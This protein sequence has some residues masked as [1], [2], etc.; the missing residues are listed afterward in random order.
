MMLKDAQQYIYLQP[1][2]LV[3]PGI[4]ITIMV[5][6]FNFIGDG[7]RDILDDGSQ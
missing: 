1:L 4:M 3:W 6:G 5:L 2:S 7:L